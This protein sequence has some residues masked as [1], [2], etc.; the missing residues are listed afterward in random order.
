MVNFWREFPIISTELGYFIV[1]L[2]RALIFKA[3]GQQ[4]RMPIMLAA[5]ALGFV[6]LAG[7]LLLAGYLWGGYYPIPGKNLTHLHA[8]Y[9]HLWLGVAADHGRQL[10]GDPDVSCYT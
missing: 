4:T 9:W 8:G 10:S 3:A 6:L 7:L 2:L 5:V 1:S